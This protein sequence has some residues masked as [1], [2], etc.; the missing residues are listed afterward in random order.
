MGLI[1]VPAL[2]LAFSPPHDTPGSCASA[3]DCNAPACIDCGC[4]NGACACADGWSGEHCETP[5]CSTRSNCS[6]HGDCH[7]GATSIQC[8]CDDGWT[9]LRCGSAVC[10]IACAHGGVPDAACTTCLGCKGAWYGPTCSL[11]NASYPAHM[12][13]ARLATLKTRANASLQAQLQ[14]KPICRAN[15]EC[16]GWGADMGR[17]AIALY[18]MLGLNFSRAGLPT[19]NGLRYP[20]GVN[21][22]PYQSRGF[23]TDTNVFPTADDYKNF[24]T[25]QL[26]AQGQGRRGAYSKALLDVWN[27]TEE[28][29]GWSFQ[30][31]QD[32]MLAVSQGRYALYK[33]SLIDD[34]SSPTGYLPR[35]DEDALAALQGLGSYAQ[36]AGSWRTFFRAWGTSAVSSSQSGGLIELVQRPKTALARTR[37]TAWLTAQAQ[38]GFTK[39]TGLGGHAGSWDPL[40][41][42]YAG[43]GNAE[44]ACYGG[45]PTLCGKPSATGDYSNWTASVAAAPV[46]L[47][48]EV[49]PLAQLVVGDPVLAS[50]VAQ[51]VQAYL[52]EEKARWPARD[53]MCP[54]SCGGSALVGVCNGSAAEEACTCN[55]C[56]S[57]RACSTFDYTGTA[58]NA[59]PVRAWLGYPKSV[60]VN[61]SLACRNGWND[62]ITSYSGGCGSLLAPC[63]IPRTPHPPPPGAAPTA[64]QL[65]ATKGSDAGLVHP[66]DDTQ[67]ARLACYTDPEGRVAARFDRYT[68]HHMQEPA[69]HR[70]QEITDPS[71]RTATVKGDASCEMSPDW[72]YWEATPNRR[73]SHAALHAADAAAR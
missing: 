35:L 33:M 52:A 25:G 60:H 16:V 39:T 50:A 67:A 37:P 46:L 42:A 3:H 57:G 69:D 2:L 9:G 43:S 17:G 19:W 4:D 6:E 34:A 18:P 61:L 70:E 47:G 27:G 32:A 13:A 59:R 53:A 7:M 65:A 56:Y 51:A 20:Y 29:S 66:E 15:D 23:A 68:F 10:T 26:W 63:Q 54:L 55:D 73:T 30:D 40:Y 22:V 14:Y 1:L 31:E 28:G 11:W 8:I 41:D 48:Y 44:Y 24:A 36:D 12:L 49:V 71:N 21:V 58:P 38:I 5:F 64:T 72:Q 62:S 45:A